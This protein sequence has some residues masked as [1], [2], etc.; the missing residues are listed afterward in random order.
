MEISGSTQDLSELVVSAQAGDRIAVEGVIRAIQPNVYKLSQRFLYI[1]ADADDATQEILLK[2]I[3]HLSQ[4]DGRSK[5]TTWVYRV[6]THYLLDVKKAKPIHNLSF[7]E[8]GEDLGN[9][10][11][12]ES[13]ADPEQA[14]LYAEIRIGCTLAL[15]HC[16][17]P[18]LRVSYILGEILDLGHQEAAEVLQI[19]PSSYRKRLSRA[20]NALTEFMQDNCGLVNPNNGC[21]CSKRLPQAQRLGRVDPNNLI[22]STTQQV[23]NNFP[24]VLTEI[25]QLET[26][27]QAA[28][29]YRAQQQPLASDNFV[30]WLRDT[31]AKQEEIRSKWLN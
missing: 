7:E 19:S 25:R 31:I 28:A 21:R 2:V 23:A 17:K 26:T 30:H 16:L 15:L 27:R 12:T 29:L 4:F 3:T 14:K 8:F 11:D 5:F 9:G 18:D 22:F 20:R 1:P 10:L 24:N 6:A 13:D